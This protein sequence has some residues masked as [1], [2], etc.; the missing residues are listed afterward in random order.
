MDESNSYFVPEPDVV[1]PADCLE[2][3][4]T[5]AQL[6][7]LYSQRIIAWPKFSEC[8]PHCEMCQMF[9]S[10]SNYFVYN[11]VLIGFILPLIGFCGLLGNGISAFIYCRPGITVCFPSQFLIKSFRLLSAVSLLCQEKFH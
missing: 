11:L 5:F 10:D 1:F 4:E 6:R 7:Q 3:N 8:L 2:S 9:A